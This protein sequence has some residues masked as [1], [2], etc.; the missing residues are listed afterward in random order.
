MASLDVDSLFTNIP[1]DETIDI[2]INELFKDKQKK[3]N[4]LTKA[5]VNEL[6]KLATKQSFFLF[7]NNFY[8][9]K[10][11][12]AM[13]NPLGPTLANSFL[14]F[15]EKKWLKDCPKSIRPI[16][17]KRYVDDIF[18][19]F[20]NLEQ[21]KKF[22]D[23]LNERHKNMSFTLEIEKDNKLSFLDIDIIRN[24]QANTFMTS[25]Y[26]KPTFSGMYTNFKS[27]IC[28]KYKYSLISSLLYRVFMICSDFNSIIT[29]IE[30]LKII[31]L[32]NAFPMRV[33]DRMILNFFNKIY[34]PKIPVHTVPK[35]K[36]ILSLEYLGKYSLEIKKRLERATKEQIPFCKINIVFS[37]KLKLR[38]LFTFK[39]KVPKNLKSLVLYKFTCSDCNVTYIG[40]TSRHYQV[41]FSEHLGISKVTNRPLKYSKNTST[42]VRDHTQCCDHKNT[43]DSFKI[44]GSAKNDYHLKIKESLNI[45][46]ENPLLNKT[47]KSFPLYLL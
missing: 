46:R 11:G 45:L 20:E 36:L 28:T 22:K 16:Y 6:L 18:V 29:E 14:C 35:M 30:K 2:C 15:Y 33:I 47:V 4:D 39:D 24:E 43:P 3:V 12:V 13:G 7:N 23:Y 41:R 26:R 25:L 38:N 32:K 17:Y 27:F 10:D 21:A 42:A 40:K 37:S 44:I 34:I 5:Q 19:L 31:W 1:L 8:I 9:Q